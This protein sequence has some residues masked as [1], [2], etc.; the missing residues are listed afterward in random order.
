MAHVPTVPN[1]A[2]WDFEYGDTDA[3]IIK[4]NA[5]NAALVQFG[6]QLRQMT[7]T[8]NDDLETVAEDKAAAAQSASEAQT[9]RDEAQEISETGLPPKA[10]NA[11]AI[12]RVADDESGYVLD[13]LLR[14]LLPVGEIKMF[15]ATVA[16]EGFRKANGDEVSRTEYAD[17]WAFAQASGNLAASEAEKDPVQFG[18]GDGSTTFTLPDYRGLHPR[19][20]DDGRGIDPGREMGTTQ[21]SQNKAHDHGGNTRNDTHG[22]GGSIGQGGLHSHAGRTAED[23]N[24]RHPYTARGNASTDTGGSARQTQTTEESNY[25]EYAGL[26][27]HYL[28]IENAG[29]HGHSLTINNNTHAHGI[30]SDGGAEARGINGPLLACIRC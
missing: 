3:A 24:H 12:L 30:N 22:H 28:Q 1:F 8:F 16:P 11:G 27:W 29:L 25:T 13:A 10:G 17:L 6:G 9:F 19:F 23:G 21:Q 18:P 26:H 15:P 20:W 14:H 4:D 2:Q 7:Q 5:R